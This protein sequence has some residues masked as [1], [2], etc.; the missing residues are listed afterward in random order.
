VYRRGGEEAENK[1]LFTH[2]QDNMSE[3]VC[4]CSED[5]L[6]PKRAATTVEKRW[7]SRKMWKHDVQ[8]LTYDYDD[9]DVC[10]IGNDVPAQVGVPITRL[11][12]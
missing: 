9:H 12:I 10:A 8:K 6:S 4:M 1:V 2:W 11:P 7:Y 3:L 5:F